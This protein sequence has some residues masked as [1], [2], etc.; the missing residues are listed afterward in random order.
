MP[1]QNLVNLARHSNNI[2]PVPALVPLYAKVTTPD[3]TYT[4]VPDTAHPATNFLSRQYATLADDAY[5]LFTAAD[6]Q[7]NGVFLE[8]HAIRLTNHGSSAIAITAVKWTPTASRTITCTNAA[9]N[10]T[11]TI[12][13]KTYTF[14]TALSQTPTAYEVLIGAADADD[15][16]NLVAAINGTAGAGT[17]YGAGTLPH[18]SVYASANGA[19][20]TITP[21]YLK[22]TEDS[23]VKTGLGIYF[24]TSDKDRLAVNG[25][26]TSTIAY[27]RVLTWTPVVI[28]HIVLSPGVP[29]DIYL[30]EFHDFR[31]ETGN[32]INISIMI[33]E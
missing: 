12:A 22:P 24:A 4:D 19:V 29:L 18:P 16:A 1:K 5:L 14:K 15:A 28:G 20:V 9:N 32:T 27:T 23:A 2:V 11:V 10:D 26:N 31:N 8:D 21:R 3:G 13:D 17:I 7:L 25:T 33:L 6:L 30:P